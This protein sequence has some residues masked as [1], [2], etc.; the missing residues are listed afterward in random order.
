MVRY[1]VVVFEV[2]E[3]ESEGQGDPQSESS[4]K[5]E[6]KD[7]EDNR[8]SLRHKRATDARHLRWTR[9]RIG[10]RTDEARNIFTATKI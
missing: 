7:V 4:V 10:R 5:K 1:L 6:R 3:L 8:K 9:R 2:L